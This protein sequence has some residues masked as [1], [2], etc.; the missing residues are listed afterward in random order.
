MRDVHTALMDFWEGFG[1]PVFVSGHV[2]DGQS[3]PYFTLVFCKGDAF[4]DGVLT[5][6][7]WHRIPNA[8]TSAGNIMAERA[9]LMGRIADRIPPQ[10]VRIPLHTGFL[11]ISRNSSDFQTYYDDPED[12][13][14]IGGR[15]SYEVRYY[16][17]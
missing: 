5:A 1:L 6:Y 13:A 2:P 4:T 17:I 8:G 3:F 14:V 11:V 9:D 12:A 10:G 16:T 7:D 15:T